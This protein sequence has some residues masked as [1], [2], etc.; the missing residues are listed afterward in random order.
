MKQQFKKSAQAGFTL[1]E[2]IVVI[3]ILG[4]LAATALPKFLDLGGDARVA[5]LN[6]AVGSLKSSGS[7]AHGAWLMKGK[8][9][10]VDLEGVSVDMHA[11]AGYP[12]QAD[13]TDWV[14]AAGLS[15]S[16]Y[17]IVAPGT[18]AVTTGPTRN[19][20]PGAN[21]FAVVPKSA[22][23]HGDTCFVT[24]T[25]TAGSEPTYSALPDPDDC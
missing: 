25:M 2:L 12:L 7:M 19:P 8:P 6:A 20:A 15:D 11:T 17:T 22:A 18:A 24:V 13:Y 16:D 5:S 21:G 14:K 3:V 1:I 10:S 9:A 4:I 23:A